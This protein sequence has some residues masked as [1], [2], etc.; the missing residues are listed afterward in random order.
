MRARRGGELRRASGR[1]FNG[2]KQLNHVERLLDHGDAAIF[3]VRDLV[4]ESFSCDA[5]PA[6][7]VEGEEAFVFEL[8]MQLG[9]VAVAKVRV[10]HDYG[11]R[12]AVCPQCLPGT[13]QAAGLEHI[14]AVVHE[15][16]PKTHPDDGIIFDQEDRFQCVCLQKQYEAGATSLPRG[17]DRSHRPR[18]E[19][20]GD[21]G[22]P[23]ERELQRCATWFFGWHP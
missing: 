7:L 8:G 20:G 9:T 1:R 18:G 12:G 16:A 6:D 3:E 13:F 23:D 5:D 17:G 22:R 15:P 19:G 4:R 2:C 10:G 21:A 14:V 11:D